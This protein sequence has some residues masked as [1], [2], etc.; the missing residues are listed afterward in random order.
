MPYI[1]ISFA[2]RLVFAE[3]NPKFPTDRHPTGQVA[4]FSLDNSNIT[5]I[6]AKM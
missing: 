1:G 3:N 5:D 2:F 4:F 6:L